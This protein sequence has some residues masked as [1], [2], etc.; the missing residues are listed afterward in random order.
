MVQNRM[1]KSIKI[2]AYVH[3]Y[4][5]NHNAGSEVMLHEI[6]LDLKE[7]GHEVKVI[8]KNPG[9]EEYEGVPIFEENGP[10]EA[11]LLNWCNVIISHHYKTKNAIKFSRMYRKPLVYI[12]HSDRKRIEQRLVNKTTVALIIANSLWI[13][14]VVARGV[15]SIVVYP[16]T[17]EERYAVDTIGD[18]ITLINLSEDKGGNMFWQLARIFPDRK[19]IGV[20][21]AYGEQIIYKDELPNVTIYENST[22]IL[23][24]YRKTRIIL[25][26]SLYESWGRV[27][28]EAATSGIPAIVS[29][30]VGLV[31]SLGDAGI[32]VPHDDVAGYVA[33]INAL[34]DEDVYKSRSE[35]IKSR[36]KEVAAIFEDQMIE[37]ERKLFAITNI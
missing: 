21:G 8:T 29:P 12:E 19:F 16:P 14:K 1:T 20:K 33:A 5:P 35:L 36:S 25:M 17:K 4:L 7:K 3:G 13:Q 31:E 6:L 34:D 15:D 23:S 27:A 28:Q 30:T 26:P 22:D 32:Y 18:A 10:Q 9:A 11:Q 2:L 24:F 37:L